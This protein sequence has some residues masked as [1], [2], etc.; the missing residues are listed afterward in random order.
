MQ[1]TLRV[2]KVSQ[3]H[4]RDTEANDAQRIG[5]TRL[6]IQSGIHR[7]SVVG[8]AY[9]LSRRSIFP[10]TWAQVQKHPSRP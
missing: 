1:N 10:M 8:R 3:R 5:T 4:D 9:T 6:R 2:Q 7:L